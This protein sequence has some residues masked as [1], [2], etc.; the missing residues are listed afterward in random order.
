MFKKLLK[1][2]GTKPG[3]ERIVT[4]LLAHGFFMGIFIATY[5]LSAETLFTGVAV[6]KERLDEAFLMQGFLGVI[7]TF[8]FAYFQ[9]RIKFSTLILSIY[10][11]IFLFLAAIL[12]SFKVYFHLN[13]IYLLFV[14]MGPLTALVL[15]SFWGIFGRLFDLR[16]SKR[17]I[18]GIDTGQLTGTILA[19]ITISLLSKLQ[20]I[21]N[22]L[23]LIFISASSVLGAIVFLAKIVSV[24]NLNIV[25][26]KSKEEVAETRFGK[27]LK[28]KYVILLSVF[29]TVSV[30]VYK[31][32]DYS[33]L[34][35]T[36]MQ[37]PDEQLRLTFLS[38]F[39]GGIM[40]L[41]FLIQTFVNDRIIMN[42][43]LK[44]SLLVLPTIL[45]VFTFAAIITGSIF[46]YTQ[47]AESTFIYFF[48]CISL[49]KLFAT[50]VRDAL[51]NPAFKLFFLSLDLKVRFDI[52]AKV[53]GVINQFGNIVAGAL[54]VVLGL[55]YFTYIELIHYSFLL[56]FI[57]IGMIYIVHKL[58][59]Q[60]RNSLKHKLKAQKDSINST[61]ESNDS[62]ANMLERQVDSEDPYVAI[63]ALKVLEI[64]EPILFESKL[65]SSL[66][67]Q[68][69]LVREYALR[70]IGKNKS[71]QAGNELSNLIRRENSE[72]VKKLASEVATQIQ[73]SDKMNLSQFQFFIL[74]KSENP[75]DREFAARFLRK[76]NSED[77]RHFLIEL[78]SDVDA[79]VR[80][81]A[82]ISASRQN[83]PD[84]WPYLIEN[85]S[86]PPYSGAA[87]A[88]IVDIGP[89]VLKALE[90]AFYKTDQQ[91]NTLV[92]IV[93]IYG[94]IGG[95]KAIKYLW[96]KIDYPNKKVVSQALRSL[97][98]CNF[99]AEDV[100]VVKIKNYISRYISYIVW[101][102]AAINELPDGT[103]WNLLKD[104]LKEEN[105]AN[106]DH[107]YLLLSLIYDKQSIQLVRENINSGTIDGVTFAIE[108]LDVFVSEDIKNILVPVLDD[109]S[110]EEAI[111]RLQEY[112]P[113][114]SYTPQQLLLQIINRDYNFVNLWTKT[115]AIYNLGLLDEAEVSDDLIANL[116]NHD[117]LIREMAAWA[118]YLIDPGA[119]EKHTQRIPE[120][121]KK[122]LDE[123]IIPHN[124]G[125]IFIKSTK[126][127]K[128][129]FLK[130]I[131]IF[132]S[133]PTMVLYDIAMK[134]N[135]I[136]IL[137]NSII[138]DY[139]NV[140]D[141]AL[142]I[143]V[144][145]QAKQVGSDNTIAEFNESEIIG[146]LLMYENNPDKSQIIAESDCILYSIDRETLYDLI[147]A[148]YRA[149]EHVLPEIEDSLRRKLKTENADL[150][151]I[152]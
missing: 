108:L 118:I 22:S 129:Q 25:K 121:I 20:V 152:I 102:M 54:L 97:G 29:I 51:E 39:N 89:P 126:F 55:S 61:T 85:L 56:V 125:I 79:K 18:G 78:L 139:G 128:V 94:R 112:Y 59:N 21:D 133:L 41:S 32:V 62:I 7:S 44:V 46:G 104:S 33:F 24:Y 38:V 81:T 8:L 9:N 132:A 135:E 45:M 87:F 134:M 6:F 65:L 122:E 90:N 144:R 150:V 146:D 43:G 106:Y 111:R 117:S 96:K 113:R 137:K 130:K 68:S 83:N 53:E 17:I 42:Y 101:N 138:Y 69:A 84:L 14:M 100:K 119:Y 124:T 57:L 34:Q 35:V 52:Q 15:L 58:Y 91:V 115:C 66:R 142:Y 147:P 3:E 76:Y 98:A 5:Q 2:I 110:P 19:F 151:H 31:F 103:N 145:G 109:I 116:F 10:V 30:I 73:E 105:E 72:E 70:K 16:Q 1:I 23:N 149:Y 99:R 143:L 60:Y 120:K 40:I 140:K 93:R 64:I 127:H 49:S 114:E 82:M 67:H 131:R 107:L 77:Y 88:A 26:K 63:F 48:L 123:V 86:I 141:S 36:P 47:G 27:I 75:I 148:K 4:L 92:Q 74:V 13:L 50:S 80:G 28:D 12:F 136:K 11:G 37:F 95:E 71:I